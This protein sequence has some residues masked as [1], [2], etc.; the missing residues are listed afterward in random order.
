MN[1][2]KRV[3]QLN[4]NPLFFYGWAGKPNHAENAVWCEN[5]QDAYL[6]DNQA[7]ADTDYERLRALGFSV[8]VE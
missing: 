6:Y 1:Y 5:L 8:S 4:H 7:D 2:I 3:D